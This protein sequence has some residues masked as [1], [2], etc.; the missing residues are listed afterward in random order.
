MQYQIIDTDKN[1][2]YAPGDNVIMIVDAESE[3]EALTI[4]LKEFGFYNSY[5]MTHKKYDAEM[6]KDFHYV[7]DMIKV[8]AA[9]K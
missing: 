3:Q 1:M 6:H 5:N 2:N 7:T 9:N 4:F 8:E